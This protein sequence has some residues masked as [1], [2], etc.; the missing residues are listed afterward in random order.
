LSDEGLLD[1]GLKVRSLRL[2]DEFIEQD[3]PE[4]MI[5]EAGL[6]ADGILRCALQ[7][8][9]TQPLASPIARGE[10]HDRKTRVGS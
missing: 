10:R 7:A 9:G 5:A 6:D 3:K 8:Y 2:P 4:R 1:H